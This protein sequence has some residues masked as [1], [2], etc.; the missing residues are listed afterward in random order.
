MLA[1][2]IRDLVLPY[3]ASNYL[4]Y[5]ALNH[6]ACRRD[7]TIGK[8]VNLLNKDTF[9]G[10]SKVLVDFRLK[11]S[12]RASLAIGASYKR[13]MREFVIASYFTI[14]RIFKRFDFG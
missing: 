11:I 5:K 2:K 12:S 3:T 9:L 10:V 1:A 7:T 14:I 13:R 4:F 6:L 8:T